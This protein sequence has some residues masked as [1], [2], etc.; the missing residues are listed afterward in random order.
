MRDVEKEWSATYG[1]SDV[2][3]TV[4]GPAEHGLSA[5][6]GASPIRNRPRLSEMPFGE[7]ASPRSISWALS[8]PRKRGSERRLGEPGAARCFS[9]M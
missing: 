7:G 1:V 5:D 8:S 4:S 3:R 2:L 9:T 6:A